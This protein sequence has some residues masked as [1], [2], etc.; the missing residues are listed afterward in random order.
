MTSRWSGC[1]AVETP[2]APP[3]C[4]VLLVHM[5]THFCLHEP[6]AAAA[7]AAAVAARRRARPFCR[8]LNC[9]AADCHNP[10]PPHPYPA[11]PHLSGRHWP[12]AFHHTISPTFPS[13]FLN[14]TMAE[15][16]IRHRPRP[17]LH[18]TAPAS[19]STASAPDPPARGATKAG[20]RCT[21]PA[22]SWVPAVYT[23]Q[24]PNPG[25]RLLQKKKGTGIVSA[26]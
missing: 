20:S 13:H 17:P 14:A 19:A 26:A 12:T 1:K 21:F 11:H 16:S 9:A 2:T 25:C 10:P 23:A 22:E 3:S 24:P 18:R 6:I 15:R 4:S 7:A 5:C 8:V